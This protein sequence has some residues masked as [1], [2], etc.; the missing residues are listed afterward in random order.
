M[1]K[2][3][4]IEAAVKLVKRDASDVAVLPRHP[5]ERRRDLGWD[6]GISNRLNA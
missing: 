6:H 1:T 3:C 2:G 4:W 5:P